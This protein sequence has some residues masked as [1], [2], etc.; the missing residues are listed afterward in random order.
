MPRAVDLASVPRRTMAFSSFHVDAG[1]DLGAIDPQIVSAFSKVLGHLRRNGTLP[2]GPPTALYRPDSGGGVEVCAGYPVGDDFE[3][4]DS[5]G[6]VDIGGVEVVH[7]THIGHYEALPAVREALREGAEAAGRSV[8][9]AG[10]R[11]E[12]YWSGPEVTPEQT[13]TELYWP[14]TPA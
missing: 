3:A 13:R 2:G 6:R 14:L 5:I 11:W 12:E 1:V 9:D 10:A 8:D 4:T 7:I